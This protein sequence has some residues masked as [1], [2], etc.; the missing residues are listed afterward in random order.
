MTGKASLWSLGKPLYTTPPKYAL[1]NL[2]TPSN[3]SETKYVIYRGKK[4]EGQY[5]EK[6]MGERENLTT[7]KSLV[8]DL[9]LS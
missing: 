9:V 7:L 5:S 4:L 1:L 8:N 3:Q 6:S 2:L